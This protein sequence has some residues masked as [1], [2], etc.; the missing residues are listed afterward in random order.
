MAATFETE[1]R[2]ELIADALLPHVYKKLILSTALACKIIY[3]EV[4]S[5]CKCQSSNRH[6][7]LFLQGL[8]FLAHAGEN[9][10]DWAFKYLEAFESI[11]EITYQIR[12]C[13][14]EDGVKQKVLEILDRGGARECVELFSS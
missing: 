7:F 14:L 11:A 10:A 8:P 4:G 5:F 2:G 13:D 1:R 3:L 6:V 12:Q 9:I